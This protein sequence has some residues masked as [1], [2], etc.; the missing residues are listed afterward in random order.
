VS[1]PHRFLT[2]VGFRVLWSIRAILFPD[3]NFS[4]A[5]ESKN[6]CSKSL[7]APPHEEV[8][9]QITPGYPAIT[10]RSLR[11]SLNTSVVPS[12]PWL[13]MPA[14]DAQGGHDGPRRAQEASAER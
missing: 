1:G 10:S 14:L 4:P 7:A 13:T 11:I 8:T 5:Q 2:M 3:L 6:R 12:K 9:V